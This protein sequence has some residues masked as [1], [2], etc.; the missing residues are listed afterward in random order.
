MKKGDF[1]MCWE[2]LAHEAET[3][4]GCFVDWEERFFICPHCDEP[5]YEDDWRDEDFS[6][7]R[8]Y[9]PHVGLKLYCPVCENIII[10][11][12]DEEDG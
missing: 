8:S 9:D 11:E 12:E 2:K 10:G 3:V 7:G 6:M 1:N 5:I 4:Y